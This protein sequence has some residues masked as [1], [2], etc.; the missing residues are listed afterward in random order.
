[1]NIAD[2]E[3]KEKLGEGQYGVVTKVLYKP[4]NMFMA[5]KVR[6]RTFPG[7]WHR[8]AAHSSLTA[9]ACA[10]NRGRRGVFRVP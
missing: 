5:L 4:N 8:P 6:I 2:L 7:P 10:G 1:M 3:V 9:L